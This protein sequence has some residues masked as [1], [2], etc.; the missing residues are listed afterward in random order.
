[1]LLIHS[2]NSNICSLQVTETTHTITRCETD[3][4]TSFGSGMFVMPNTIDF[5][6]VFANMGFSDNLT[7]YLTL[8][9]SLSVFFILII[10]ARLK[11]RKDVEKVS[12]TC[13]LNITIHELPGNIVRLATFSSSVS[14]HHLWPMTL[15]VS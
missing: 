10:W 9:I 11:D 15:E 5:S 12:L 13:F 1:M 6:Y 14:L 4:L 3:H 7:I 2:F 8:I